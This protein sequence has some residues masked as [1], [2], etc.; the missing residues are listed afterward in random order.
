MHATAQRAGGG[1]PDPRMEYWRPT[2]VELRP[3]K[4]PA[5]N[6]EGNVRPERRRR[7]I[8]LEG[9]CPGTRHQLRSVPTAGGP[10]T[11]SGSVLSR[12]RPGPQAS[13]TARV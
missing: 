10:P 7:Q 13:W 2:A 11:A 5:P 9:S 12:A 4:Q 1:P 3:M 8:A 6:G